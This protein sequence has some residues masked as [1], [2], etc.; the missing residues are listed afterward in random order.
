MNDLSP[1]RIRHQHWAFLKRPT[2]YVKAF[3]KRVGARVELRKL[4]LQRQLKTAS[5]I[6]GRL[7]DQKGVMLADDVGLGKTSIAALIACVF[8]GLGK[9]VRVLAPN[10]TMKRRWTEE[11]QRQLGVTAE[12]AHEL[13][14]DRLRHASSRLSGHV[15][16]LRDGDIMVTTHT[17]SMNRTLDCDLLIV[18]EAHRARS[19]QSTFGKILWR[20]RHEYARILLVT[21]T[22]FSLDVA[23]LEHHLRLLNAGRETVTAAQ[24][25]GHAISKLWRGDFVDPKS[26]GTDLGTSGLAAVRKL[27]PYVVRHGV[28]DLRKERAEYGRLAE[29][30]IPPTI[31]NDD[32]LEV[33]VRAD[34]LLRLERAAQVRVKQ[35]TN[36]PRFHQGWSHLVDEVGQ[37]AAAKFDGADAHAA[38]NLHRERIMALLDE[39]GTHPKIDE[40][41]RA[42]A[43]KVSQG[44]KVVAFCDHH[45]V[46]QELTLA[47]DKAIRPRA[48]P[49]GPRERVWRSAW[50]TALEGILDSQ[51]RTVGDVSLD[52]FLAWLSCPAIRGQVA[53]WLGRV[54]KEPDALVRALRRTRPRKASSGGSIADEARRLLQTLVDR[55]SGSTRATLKQGPMALPGFGQRRPVMSSANRPHPDDHHDDGLFFDRSPDTLLAIFNSPFGPDVL[56][57]TDRLSEGIDLHRWCRHVMHYELDPSPIR[58]VQRRGRVRRIDSWAARS[59][60]PILEAIPIFAGT[61]DGQLVKIVRRRLDQFDLLLGGIATPVHEDSVGDDVR[62]QDEALAEARRTMGAVSLAV[63]RGAYA[64]KRRA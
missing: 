2:A 1:L 45:S 22:P 19:A 41:C 37:G 4:P 6:L 32:A 58:V 18:D 48:A 5:R 15:H 49:R 11:I 38:I 30:S 7:R 20:Y 43:D 44:E 24:R 35:R 56:V 42:I 61:R 53:G 9:R 50:A 54:P 21:A 10:A 57:A 13:D 34:R 47:L 17:K 29:W 62:R 64:A 31:A 26:F 60:K 28:S 14:T 52:H 40:S 25:F 8:S 55:S 33:I 12:V 63:W 59:R 36:D 16:T 23:E 39:V 3:E 46:A 27:R 51:D